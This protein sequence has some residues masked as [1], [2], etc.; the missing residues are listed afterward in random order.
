MSNADFQHHLLA[1]M[2]ICLLAISGA[3]FG[4]YV[5]AS[6]VMLLLLFNST[7]FACFKSRT[8]K[9]WFT[10][11][12]GRL[13]PD[14]TAREGGDPFKVSWREILANMDKDTKQALWNAKRGLRNTVSLSGAFSYIA[15]ASLALIVISIT[16]GNCELFG[17]AGGDGL[18]WVCCYGGG[19]RL[20]SG[21]SDGLRCGGGCF[22]PKVAAAGVAAAMVSTMML[23][24]RTARTV[25]AEAVEANAMEE[26][27]VTTVVKLLAATWTLLAMIATVA[28]SGSGATTS[29]MTA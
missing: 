3:A 8:V 7:F 27:E 21:D 25:A 5:T 18:R 1:G 10:K 24:T 29:T 19:D 9:R 12:C 15:V 17:S 11:K 6:V 23:S 20:G 13:K 2:V 16:M 26:V 4:Y 28:A 14:R 22:E